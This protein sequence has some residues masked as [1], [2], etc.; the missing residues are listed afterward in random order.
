MTNRS[1]LEVLRSSVTMRV[2]VTLTIGVG[3]AMIAM[4]AGLPAAALIGSAVAVSAVSFCRLP[5]YVPPWLR[6]MAFAAI[7]C[8]LGSGINTDF[9]EL[10][11]KWPVSLSG[12]VLVMAVI[13]FAS[14]W[15]LTSFFR[16]SKVTAI[17]AA[18]PG[19][20]SY[21]LAIAATGVGDARAIIVIQ[22]IRLLSITTCLPLVLDL[23]N[24]QHGAG[25]GSQQSSISFT[26]TTA[27]FL[28]TLLTGHVLNR[29][30]LPAAY[31]IAG[32]FLSGVL[33]YTGV[34][35]GRPYTGFLLTGFVITGSVIGSRFTTIPL[36]DIKRL[37]GA[38]LTVVVV[39]SAIAALFAV[40]AAQLLGL[41]FGQIWVS[42][43]P[44]GV[45]AMAAMALAL[46][47][48][49]AFVAT[50]HLFRIILLIFLL[51]VL[52]RVFRRTESGISI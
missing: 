24:L 34:V 29:W 49:S 17:L 14:S 36:A 27:L 5:T 37:V 32:I 35:T 19:A 15:V 10:A 26:A 23:L 6:N 3:G 11:V 45:E 33:H 48:D 18:S 20:L 4:A 7:G 31:L 43:A 28:L 2:V 22:S 38:A 16:Q 25:G 12:L 46:G 41:P 30:K 9:L 47:Y 40:L 1:L 8:S 13:L 39:S 44:G 50:H 21:S 42:Y 51:P 52:L